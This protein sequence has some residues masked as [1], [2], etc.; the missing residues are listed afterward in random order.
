MFIRQRA[1]M[2]LIREVTDKAGY[3]GAKSETSALYFVL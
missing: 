3:T 2:Q 1:A